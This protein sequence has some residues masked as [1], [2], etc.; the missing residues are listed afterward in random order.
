MNIS[1]TKEDDKI[2]E[3]MSER[4]AQLE[5]E[6]RYTKELLFVEKSERSKYE[7]AL[8]SLRTDANQLVDQWERN[9]TREKQNCEKVSKELELI[10]KELQI[11]T[12]EMSR[13]QDKYQEI[14]T[15]LLSKEEDYRSVKNECDE[16]RESIKKYTNLVGTLEEEKVASS[17]QLLSSNEVVQQLKN[18]LLHEKEQ[19]THYLSQLN[20][21][22]EEL[23]KYQT[24]NENLREHLQNVSFDAEKMLRR[25][26]ELNEKYNFVEKENKQ[27]ESL[28]SSMSSEIEL[29]KKQ[30]DHLQ[31]EKDK[32]TE[33]SQLI[34]KRNESDEQVLS[35]KIA[36]LETE[37]SVLN[38]KLSDVL[39]IARNQSDAFSQLEGSAKRLQMERAKD[40]E[41]ITQLKLKLESISDEFTKK[42]IENEK[43]VDELR[44]L[45]E[46]MNN[47]VD[48]RDKLKEQKSLEI[49]EKIKTYNTYLAESKNAIFEMEKKYSSLASSYQSLTANVA[50]NDQKLL[51]FSEANA[52]SNIVQCYLQDISEDM[53]NT[54]LG[55]QRKLC[56]KETLI[57]QSEVVISQTHKK[58]HEVEEEAKC[59]H[60]YYTEREKIF[61]E[62]QKALSTVQLKLAEAK[63]NSEEKR[64]VLTQLEDDNIFLKKQVESLTK[65][66][67]EVDAI[68]IAQMNELQ[69]INDNLKKENKRQLAF[70]EELSQKFTT[71]SQQHALLRSQYDRCQSEY[72]AQSKALGLTESELIDAKNK[73]HLL[74]KKLSATLTKLGE[75]EAKVSGLMVLKSKLECTVDSLHH[76][77]AQASEKY[78]SV[79]NSKR[80]E[81][82]SLREKLTKNMEL[83]EKQETS[84]SDTYRSIENYEK[85]ILNL[86]AAN[87]KLKT[88]TSECTAELERTRNERENLLRERDI[89][90][91]KYNDLQDSL[92]SKQKEAVE[93]VST[94]L[95][96]I[97]S[98]C[99]TQE[100]ELEKLRRENFLLKNSLNMFVTTTQPKTETIF[101]ERLNLTEGPLRHPKKRTESKS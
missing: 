61:D 43:L 86:K 96:K 100:N 94:E 97:I 62:Q 5:R 93:K 31:K 28:V 56:E 92:P 21:Q 73:E 69:E 57:S 17:A 84:M 26:I 78:N 66:L 40:E 7:S 2:R 95:K 53:V 83:V 4:V 87:N 27:L 91:K 30:I 16:L 55:L 47:V 60:D 77:L 98:L 58:L 9:A 81:I 22:G 12:D 23:R 1:S 70:V 72:I 18:D 88:R 76:Q 50:L 59:A 99:T 48:E 52:R 36:A 51:A 3:T 71:E 37:I 10:K 29:L 90:I 24:E 63:E 14:Q 74:M 65:E 89:M 42:S 20:S 13:L 45:R 39:E 6:L 101:T 85:T 15:K 68:V 67:D 34:L 25:T 32:L 46:Q 79:L 49:E 38:N 35:T 19:R 11:S 33:E 80:E 64:H 44:T 75:E 82:N 54:L 41:T 8:D